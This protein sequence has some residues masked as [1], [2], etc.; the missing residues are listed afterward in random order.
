MRF[1]DE[2][3]LHDDARCHDD[4]QLYDGT[5]FRDGIRHGHHS[6]TRDDIHT[7]NNNSLARLECK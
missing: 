4:T 1:I 7:H 2:H 5:H 3:R 6:S